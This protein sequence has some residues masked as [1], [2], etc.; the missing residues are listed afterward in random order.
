MLLLQFSNA[1]SDVSCKL[2]LI[3]AFVQF[4]SANFDSLTNTH[5]VASLLSGLGYEA[6][7]AHV[8][9]LVAMV[10]AFDS[11]AEASTGAA[12]NGKSKGKYI[13]NLYSIY[14]QYIICFLSLII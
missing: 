4:G 14:I 13:Y 9:F 10:G 7:V 1:G 12:E 6:I 5:T 3:S 8:N 11:A 2:A